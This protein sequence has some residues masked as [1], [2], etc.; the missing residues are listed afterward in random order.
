VL[1][2][3]SR[4]RKYIKCCFCDEI[5]TIDHIFFDCKIATYLWGLLKCATGIVDVPKHFHEI[6]VWII[7]FC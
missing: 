6:N 2:K 7:F 5:E 3:R 4:K 1:I